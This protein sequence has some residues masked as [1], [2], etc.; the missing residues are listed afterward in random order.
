MDN[1]TFQ[2]AEEKDSESIPEL[3]NFYIVTTTATFDQDQISRE[4]FRQRIYIG[5]EKYQTYVI[6]YCNEI[7]GFCFLT[8]YRKKEAYDRTA[9]S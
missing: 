9:L 4:E 2:K 3:Y 8:Q 5:H 1:L 7:V 6:Q